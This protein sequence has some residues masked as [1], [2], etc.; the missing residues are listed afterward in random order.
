MTASAACVTAGSRRQDGGRVSVQSGGQAACVWLGTGLR[1]NALRTDDWTELE[2]VVDGLASRADVKAVV[3]R[4][5]QGTFSS[6]SDLTEWAAVEAG[7]VDRT[8]AAMESAL[9]AVERLGAVSIAAIEGAAVGAGCELALA[10]DLRVM[11]R[12]ARIGMPVVRHG[13]RLSP[14]FALRLIHIV[15]VARARD[16]LFTGRLVGSER[17]EQWGLTSQVADDEEFDE[18]LAGL[19]ECVTSQPRS[20]LVAAKRSTNRALEQDRIHLHE[21]DWRYVDENEFFDRIS[22]FLTH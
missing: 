17:A 18:H 5:V 10:C 22:N 7:Y 8:F 3:F 2:R 19:V 21:P 9:A 16:L 20:G 6:G 14:A 13:I 12:S 11:A 15:G 4:G 1:R